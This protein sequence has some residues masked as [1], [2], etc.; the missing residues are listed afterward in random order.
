M[1]RLA[2]SRLLK[3]A[4]VCLFIFSIAIKVF[5]N[6]SLLEK[7]EAIINPLISA[8]RLTNNPV[9]NKVAETLLSLENSESSYD[10][11]LRDADL[12]VNHIKLIA[13]AIKTVH[14]NG[15]PS[16][17]SFSMS[18]NSNLGDE[19]VFVLV[20]NLPQ[21][22]T[23]I[24]LVQSGIGDKGAEALITWATNAKQLRWLCVEGNVFSND[25]ND[26]LSKLGQARS[27]LLVVF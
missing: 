7:E 8:L 12:N 15:G 10:L 27:G 19:G 6:D 1:K 9:S 14:D 4:T 2:I 26:R 13:E 5:A 24:G 11:H 23:E 3:T 25:I 20:K 18:Y 16:L 21:T 22:I 17:R